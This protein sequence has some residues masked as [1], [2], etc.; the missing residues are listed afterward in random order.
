MLRETIASCNLL[1]RKVLERTRSWN[2]VWGKL[3]ARQ[4]PHAANIEADKQKTHGEMPWVLSG[5]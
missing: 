5:F 3:T 1:P 2:N 4:K